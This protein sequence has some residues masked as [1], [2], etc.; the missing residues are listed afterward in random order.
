VDLFTDFILATGEAD[1][2]GPNDVVNLLTRRGYMLQLMLRGREGFE[3]IQGGSKIRGDVLIRDVSTYRTYKPGVKQTWPNPQVLDNWEIDWRFSLDHMAWNDQEIELN[4]SPNLKD[5]IRYQQFVNMRK[6]INMRTITSQ[7]HGMEDEFWAVPSFAD[8]EGS[9][10][11]DINSLALFSNELQAWDT[12][13]HGVSNG[14]YSSYRAAGAG[15][16][17]VMGINKITFPTWDNARSGYKSAGL[18][19]GTAPHLFEAFDDVILSTGIKELPGPGGAEASDPKS[20]HNVC[21]TGKTGYTNFQRALRLNQ[22]WFRM[23]AQNPAYPGP[24]FNGIQLM[25]VEALDTA[26]IYPTAADDE[27]GTES[28]YGTWDDT[29]N[30]SAPDHTSGNDTADNDGPRYHFLDFSYLHKAMHSR[31][32]F[33]KL[34]MKS[35]S[36]QAT[37]HVIPCDTWHNNLCRDLRRQGIVFP[38]AHIA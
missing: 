14:L 17:E 3:S 32:Y 30:T 7:A 28:I 16:N 29:T 21:V 20:I 24:N 15:N 2:G 37:D 25:Y 26:A 19:T 34:P 8:M 23:G 27:H 38:M 22:D 35:P 4:A 6:K 1:F 36:N 33:R 12:A 9:A 13:T 5:S 18:A 10:G 31:R 11:K